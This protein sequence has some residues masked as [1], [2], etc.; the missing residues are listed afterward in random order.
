MNN[1]RH[2]SDYINNDDWWEYFSNNIDESLWSGLLKDLNKLVIRSNK[3]DFTAYNYLHLVSH[4]QKLLGVLGVKRL[5]N[6]CNY[7]REDAGFI[8]F[9]NL[10]SE[11]VNR[12]GRHLKY[13]YNIDK[14]CDYEVT[15]SLNNEPYNRFGIDLDEYIC[16]TDGL[17]DYCKA[18]FRLSPYQEWRNDRIVDKVTKKIEENIYVSYHKKLSKR[19]SYCEGVEYTDRDYRLS[20]IRTRYIL[21]DIIKSKLKSTLNLIKLYK[22]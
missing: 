7:Y 18:Y 5:R 6:F 13:N 2:L 4:F 8:S 1:Y 3:S 16:L 21:I 17:I 14:P 20:V 19:Y 12:H 15:Y 11:L 9:F 22:D 10:M